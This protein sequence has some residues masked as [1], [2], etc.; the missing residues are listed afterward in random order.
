MNLF[1]GGALLV[2][3]VKVILDMDPGIDDALAIMLALNSPELEIIGIT[4][5]SGNVHVEK[6]SVNT[7]RVLE[8]V[9]GSD[10]PVYKG[11]DRPLVKDLVTAEWVHG[12]D[13]LG[14]AGLPTPS[15]RPRDG[16][17]KFITETLMSEKD[18]T[19]VATGPLTNIALTL[20]L[21]PEIRSRL[22]RLVLMGGAFGLTPYG[23]GNA[24]PV[25]E[26]NIHVDPEAAKIVFESGVNPLCVGLDI[27]T[28]PA[29]TLKREDVERL[30][31]AG[32]PEART[33]ARIIRR[34]VERFGFMQLHDP[35]AVAAAV[36][37]SL[38][39][40][41]MQHV[42]VVCE[43]DLTRGQTIIERRFW[44]QSQ[45]NAEICTKVQPQ[46]FLKMFF[47]RLGAE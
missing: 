23:H 19:V 11:A 31:K 12:E 22:G 44:V 47:E 45:P 20:A 35:L 30:A 46:D 38:F 1:S 43:G 2:D 26:F 33:A 27:T 18:V 7:L 17:V 32:T 37:P 16:A 21:E 29:T 25:S 10:V 14:D 41:S 28:D 4:T 13:G 34:F 6:T 5:V 36:K 40:T 15:R 8:A 39:K 24:T 3:V 42:Y 9:G